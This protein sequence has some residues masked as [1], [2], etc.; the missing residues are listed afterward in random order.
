MED[1]QRTKT[2]L[3]R[4]LEE[5]RRSNLELKRSESE[6]RKL[7]E[8]LQESQNTKKALLNAPSD[9][10]WLLDLNGFILDANETAAT[11]IGRPVEQLIGKYIWDFIPP[12][13]AHT[14]QAYADQVI[15]SGEPVRF[16]DERDRAWFDNVVYPISNEEGK[17]AQIAVVARDITQRKRM[18]EALRRS[19]L[20]L[21]L[22]TDNIRDT[23]WVMD[24]DFNTIWISP[25]VFRNRGYT[26][27]EICDTP[28]DHH[29]TPASLEKARQAMS[30]FAAS[31]RWNDPKAEITNSME[32]EFY[33]KDGS[34]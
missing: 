13:I 31:D 30:E 33:R 11:R 24:L 4:E 20:E 18:E 27:E 14:R 15:R 1:K 22:I 12:K 16:E 23:V 25:S 19:E 9:V 6:R 7:E 34:T 29:I 2:Q 5:L 26:F 10:I 28:L 8:A 21:R 17:V 32:L 3:I